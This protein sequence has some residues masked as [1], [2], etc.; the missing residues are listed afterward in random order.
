M[1]NLNKKNILFLVSDLE[2]G[3][4]QKSLISLLQ[5]FNYEKYDVDLLVLCP[6]GIFLNQVP[7]EVNIIS[8]NIPLEF[9]KAFPICIKELIK[10]NEYLLAIK[11]GINLVLSR[12]DRG[13][14]GIYM[15]RQIPAIDKEY[16]VAIDY[17]G[18]HILYYMVDKIKAKKKISYFH[19]DYKKWDYYKAADKKYYPKVDYIVTISD[20]CKESL[21]E[22]FPECKDKTKVIHNISSTKII[23]KLA[24]EKCPVVFDK[25]YINLVMV[26]RP[27]NVKGYDFA[28][29]ACKKLKND[30]YKVRIYSV[31]TSNEISKF[32]KMVSDNNLENEFI[33]LGETN[34]PYCI[35]KEADIYIHPSRFEGKSVAIDEAKILA[36]PIIISNFTTSKDHIN[37][38]VNGLIV[39]LSSQELAL[40]IQKMIDDK[41]LR[42]YLISNLKNENLGNEDEVEKLYTLID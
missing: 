8:T 23:T 15:S 14:A 28:I 17:N 30:G 6:S 38:A 40:G 22:I 3:G 19:S 13:R 24:M 42:E 32:E 10:K 12:I 27:S 18:Q 16:D 5:S 9:F 2:S 36:K 35:M 20:I 26:G 41:T 21:D 25:S 37:N 7:S 4:F 29:E 33:F 34:N 31:G 11:R 39:G 1:I